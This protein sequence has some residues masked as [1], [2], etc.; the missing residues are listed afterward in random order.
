MKVIKDPINKEFFRG[1]I[2]TKH[3][4][5]IREVIAEFTGSQ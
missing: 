4:E 5:E 1:F 2:R 3:T